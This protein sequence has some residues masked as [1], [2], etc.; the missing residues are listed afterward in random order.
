[1][2]VLT[3]F[4][5]HYAANA[6]NDTNG[7]TLSGGNASA[8]ANADVAPTHVSAG[9]APTTALPATGAPPTFTTPPQ[10]PE[11]SPKRKL[12]PLRRF[13]RASL[14]VIAKNVFSRQWYMQEAHKVCGYTCCCGTGESRLTCVPTSFS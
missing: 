14:V 2:A 9:D 8:D 6:G 13:R 11:K 4:R 10:T 7:L 12:A 3:A 1:M 5:L